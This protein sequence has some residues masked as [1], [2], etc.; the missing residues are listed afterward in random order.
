VIN[1][2]SHDFRLIYQVTEEVWLCDKQ[3][4]TKVEGDIMKYKQDLHN[5]VMRERKRLA[6]DGAIKER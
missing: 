1:L 4:I 2:V 6:K 5:Q 3:T